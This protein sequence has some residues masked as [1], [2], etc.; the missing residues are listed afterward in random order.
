MTLRTL[1]ANRSGN[2]RTETLMG[3]EYRVLPVRM[4][5]QGVLVANKGP[6]FYSRSEI[7]RTSQAWNNIPIVVDHPKD[8]DRFI[9]ARSPDVLN[10]SWIGFV[11]NARMNGDSLDAEA[12]IDVERVSEVDPSLR[13]RIDRA[14]PVEVS[15][16]LGTEEVP[17]TGTYNS[18]RYTHRAVNLAPDHLAVLPYD[19]GA[20][21]L[22]DG[23][24]LAVNNCGVGTSGFQPG[25]TCAKGGG[26]AG[27]VKD[28]PVYHGGTSG[29][30]QFVTYYTTDKSVAK[31]YADMSNDRYGGGGKVHK[32][33]LTISNPAPSDVISKIADKIGIDNEYNTPASVFDSEL[34]GEE[35]VDRLTKELRAQGYDGAVLKDIPYGAGSEFDAYIK[36]TGAVK[37]QEKPQKPSS[38]PAK[39]ATPSSS[40]SSGGGTIRTKQGAVVGTKT[41]PTF[42]RRDPKSTQ[43]QRWLKSK[44]YTMNSAA[45]ADLI[46]WVT[47][48][49]SSGSSEPFSFWQVTANCGGNKSCGC[50][51]C[52]MDFQPSIES[53]DFQPTS[54][55]EEGGWR[56]LEGGAKVYIGADGEVR[57]GGPNG[58]VIGEGSSTSPSTK[59]KPTTYSKASSKATD[60]TDKAYEAAAVQDTKAQILRAEKAN[61]AAAKAHKAAF[62][63][64]KSQ[65]QKKH[66]E[67]QALM[68]EESAV[69]LLDRY[70][71]F[72]KS[73][74]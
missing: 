29:E 26:G 47:R 67:S 51:Q 18:K 49:E 65:A 11:F 13:D 9:S 28:L 74:K 48:Y 46:D 27:A 57:A 44:G 12:W 43:S 25:N 1:S 64:A 62:K 66:H 10:Q 68:H 38:T 14:E 56:T 50:Q 55:S 4:I 8:G 73:K 36:F 23:C 72:G 2:A 3:R 40:G 31:T 24:G 22:R 70:Y 37:E 6:L 45:D 30:G 34:H 58:E 33:N 19:E 39:K 69:K 5:R 7:A 15:T 71:K 63:A 35:D 52:T 60:A 17:Q 41:L 32:S 53:F 16:G 61:R 20:C 21:S 42:V 59:N 54:N